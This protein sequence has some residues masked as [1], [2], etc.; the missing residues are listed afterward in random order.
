[1]TKAELVETI[2]AQTHMTKKAAAQVLDL[3]FSK[4]GHAVRSD[5]RFSYPGFGTWSLRSRKPRKVRHPQTNEVMKLKAYRTVG[6]RPAKELK[7]TL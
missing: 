7:R 1:M 6:F 5:N 4:I 2:A 3:V